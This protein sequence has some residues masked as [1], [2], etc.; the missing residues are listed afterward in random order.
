MILALRLPGNYVELPNLSRNALG[1][2]DARDR[3]IDAV[4]PSASREIEGLPGGELRDPAFRANGVTGPRLDDVVTLPRQPVQRQTCALLS[5][6][7][8][9]L[10]DRFAPCFRTS[11]PKVPWVFI[12]VCPML[13]PGIAGLTW[14]PN[15]WHSRRPIGPTSVLKLPRTGMR[16][17]P[18]TSFFTFF[19]GFFLSTK[20]TMAR[21]RLL[22]PH[23]VL[24]PTARPC[25]A[26]VPI[27]SSCFF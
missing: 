6:T 13:E 23:F 17:L 24:L 2:Y 22:Q 12:L 21:S 5:M 25:T 8:P 27:H 10:G 15:T 9:I 14:L 26:R 19:F 7:A 3:G 1:A 16:I 20:T 4:G 18:G 11:R